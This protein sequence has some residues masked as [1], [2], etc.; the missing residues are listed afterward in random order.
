MYVQ[1]ST[2]QSA[3]KTASVVG[4]HVGFGAA[5]SGSV[6]VSSISMARLS[7]YVEIQ[8]III[9]SANGVIQIQLKSPA[10]AAATVLS[11]SYIEVFKIL[12]VKGSPPAQEVF[13]RGIRIPC[14]CLT[15]NPREAA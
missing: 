2:N 10:D 15:A 1:T 5:A 13:F 11:G 14:W 9:P 4:A 3:L 8:G 6:L 7:L 12:K